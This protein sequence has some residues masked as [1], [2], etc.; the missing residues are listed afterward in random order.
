MLTLATPCQRVVLV[1]SE[2][3]EKDVVAC[4][5]IAADLH[6]SKKKEKQRKIKTSLEKRFFVRTYLEKEQRK[7]QKKKKNKSKI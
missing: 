3:L 6:L 7:T 5:S 2:E 1:V 4:L